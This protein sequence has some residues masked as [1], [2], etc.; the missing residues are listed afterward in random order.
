M[1][2]EYLKEEFKATNTC[3]D[4]YFIL[5]NNVYVKIYK[6]YLD[7]GIFKMHS[8]FPIVVDYIG[9]DVFY[10][11]D[12]GGVILNHPLDQFECLRRHQETSEDAIIFL[13]D[14]EYVLRK[15]DFDL[16]LDPYIELQKKANQKNV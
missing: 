2:I 5:K 15:K 9:D 1:I 3:Q 14:M 11:R 16:K 7:V 4:S 6:K 10:I 8:K 13:H 12:E